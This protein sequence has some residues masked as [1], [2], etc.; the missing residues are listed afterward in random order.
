M[1]S[2]LPSF[3]LLPTASIARIAAYAGTR[4]PEF[5]NDPAFGALV[6]LAARTDIDSMEK[7]RMVG[8]RYHRVFACLILQA[9]L[10]MA[11]LGIPRPPRERR[12]RMF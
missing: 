1:K 9:E 6:R 7:G 4:Y 10:E 12:R 3:H 8:K 5:R 2:E 11:A